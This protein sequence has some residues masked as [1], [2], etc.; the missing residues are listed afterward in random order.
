M[1][2]FHDIEI[3]ADAQSAVR[4]PQLDFKLNGVP[5][6]FDRHILLHQANHF[7]IR[8]QAAGLALLD[9][10]VLEILQ[11]D[12]TDRDN[13]DPLTGNFVDHYISIRQIIVDDI[14]A[15]LMMLTNTE[16]RHSMPASWVKDMWTKGFEIA[17]VYRP[18]SELHLNGVM[19]FEF[20]LPF[21]LHKTQL[22]ATVK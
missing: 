19:T 20:D 7:R 14:D 12:K 11:H 9:H 5:I 15:D 17:S 6:K 21:W 18:G 10:N 4:E 1:T 2:D 8:Y 22:L 16:F 13:T 3:L